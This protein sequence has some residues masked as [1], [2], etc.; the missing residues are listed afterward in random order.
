MIE[1]LAVAADWP[2]TRTLTPHQSMR[3]MDLL[4][5]SPDARDVLGLKF[6][7]MSAQRTYTMAGSFMHF[8]LER[9][10]PERL[11]RLYASGGDFERVYGEDLGTLA[12]QWREMLSEIEVPAADLE[13]ARERFRQPGVFQRPCPHANAARMNRAATLPR[14]QAVRLV[15]A[16][17]KDAPGE[18]RYRLELAEL[19]AQGGPDEVTEARAIYDG[20]ATGERGIVL[21]AEALRALVVLDARASDQAGVRAKVDRALELALDDDR[22]RQFEAMDAALRAEGFGG[23]F[24]RAYFFEAG[25]DLAWSFLA[26]MFGDDGLGWYLVGVQ[27][28]LRDLHGLAAIALPRALERGVPTRRFVRNAS[29][30]LAVSAWRAHDRAALDVAT[31]ALAG[32]AYE[33]DRA[34]AADWRQRLAFTSR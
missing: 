34:L 3:A 5:F 9:H 32:S 14:P 27:S 31:T 24:L 25:D 10:G 20:F 30:R 7:T 12:A 8:L 19:L 26:A 33:T 29:R 15:R 21:A 6:L 23:Y 28:H 4:G 13:A 2:G 16:V 18:P 1:G 11:R 17:C 22:L